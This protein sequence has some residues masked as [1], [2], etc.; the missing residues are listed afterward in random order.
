[1][2][3][4][5]ACEFTAT[6]WVGSNLHV[7]GVSKRVVRAEGL[8]NSTF[9]DITADVQDSAGQMHWDDWPLLFHFTGPSQNVI[10]ERAIARNPVQ[11]TGKAYDNGDCYTSEQ[12]TNNLT[13][14]SAHC[15][16]AFDAA[17]DLKGGPHFIEDAIA[18]RIGNRAFRVWDGPVYIK[19]A[20]AAYDGDGEHTSSALGSNAAIWVR[21]EAVVE[22]F[23]SL[24]STQPFILAESGQGCGSLMLSD[25]LVLLETQRSYQTDEARTLEPK[26]ECRADNPNFVAATQ[27]NVSYRNENSFA[28]T[29]LYNNVLALSG[30]PG[31]NALSQPARLL[32]EEPTGFMWPDNLL[33]DWL[34][35]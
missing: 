2:C 5:D 20:L 1:G 12:Y 16:E 17:F 29:S 3:Q 23:T 6:D 21:G 10:V 15:L 19:N 27:N 31:R 33:P 34:T 30:S 35:P 22:D 24:S 28:Q 14:R 32:S 18:L 9:Q 13:F 4:Q 25:S 8:Q 11:R 7:L 26:L